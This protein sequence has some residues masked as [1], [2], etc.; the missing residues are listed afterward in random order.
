MKLYIK[1]MERGTFHEIGTNSHDCLKIDE[2]G[3]LYYYNL[4]CGES[5]RCGTYAF[6]DCNG[7]VPSKNSIE[8]INTGELIYSI[9]ESI[10]T[11]DILGNKEVLCIILHFF[12]EDGITYQDKKEGIFKFTNQEEMIEDAISLIK[13]WKMVDSKHTDFK[14]EQEENHWI[15]YAKNVATGLVRKYARYDI[16][17]R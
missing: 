8:Y 5:S 3:N 15:V 11:Y 13:L 6:C 4:Q 16:E 2:N 1:D 9:G 12:E 14:L 10:S 7:N 17:Y